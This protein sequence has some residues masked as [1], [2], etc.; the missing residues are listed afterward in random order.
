[1]QHN[2]LVYTLD[3]LSSYCWCSQPEIQTQNFPRCQTVKKTDPWPVHS[4]IYTSERTSTLAIETFEN[5]HLS[6]STTRPEAW[7]PR[8]TK[9]WRLCSQYR[10]KKYFIRATLC[11]VVCVRFG[12]QV[13]GQD[14][15]PA[16]F[17]FSYKHVSSAVILIMSFLEKSM[18]KSTCS[19]LKVFYEDVHKVAGWWEHLESYW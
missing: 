7:G 1:M 4:D 19:I 8:W 13:S 12:Y 16:I 10:Y 6:L 5:G 18:A 3:F 15:G 14:R 17:Q 11:A 9:R 2:G